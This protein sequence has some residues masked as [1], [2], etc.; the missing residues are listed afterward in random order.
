MVDSLYPS[1]EGRIRVGG[2]RESSTA[3]EISMIGFFPKVII[4]SIRTRS[5]SC[6]TCGSSS[7]TVFPYPTPPV[8]R[9]C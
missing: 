1:P 9:T 2:G 5:A 3:H 8:S 4:D 6:E 7:K